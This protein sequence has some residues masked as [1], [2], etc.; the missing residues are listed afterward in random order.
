MVAAEEGG[1]LPA[2][3]GG[4]ARHLLVLVGGLPERDETRLLSALGGCPGEGG[5]RV[6]DSHAAELLTSF[7]DRVERLDEQISDLQADRREVLAEVK[8]A[9]FDVKA[10]REVIRRRKSDDPAAW[11]THDALVALYTEAVGFGGGDLDPLFDAARD[12]ALLAGGGAPPAKTKAPSARDKKLA[13]A[14]AWIRGPAN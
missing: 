3:S 8:S 1:R 14:L 7:V 4:R 2:R 6:S 11:A 9:G 12:R 10:L 5:W 13:E